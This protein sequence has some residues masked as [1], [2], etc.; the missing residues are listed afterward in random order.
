[1]AEQKERDFIKVKEIRAT[2]FNVREIAGGKGASIRV[3]VNPA[4]K[5]KKTG[6]WEKDVWFDIVVWYEGLVKY[7][8]GLQKD[9]KI[10]VEGG[11]IEL[12]RFT[13]DGVERETWQV[14]LST[15]DDVDFDIDSQLGTFGPA[16]LAYQRQPNAA[17]VPFDIDAPF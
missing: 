8:A 2:V 15:F 12:N 13:K 5:N 9:A 6:E 17:E 14:V 16:E 7:A 11:R 3:K 1:M 10:F 4:R